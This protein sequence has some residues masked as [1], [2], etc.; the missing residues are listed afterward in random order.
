[1]WFLSL[2]CSTGQSSQKAPG[3]LTRRC[4]VTGGRGL[5]QGRRCPK[6]GPSELA[7]P[8]GRVTAASPTLLHRSP[9]LIGR[10]GLF[11]VSPHQP[12]EL[13]AGLSVSAGAGRRGPGVSFEILEWVKWWSAP[14]FVCLF[15]LILTRGHF[16][17][18]I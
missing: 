15:L 12:G 17:I 8:E 9:V 11:P 14:L 13:R 4:W 10:A 2:V 6:P 1:M 7:S 3:H 5:A 18:N 16:S